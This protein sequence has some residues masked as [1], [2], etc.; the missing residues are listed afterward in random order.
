MLPPAVNAQKHAGDFEIGLGVAYGFETAEDGAL[1]MNFNVYYSVI[2]E[3]R[4]GADFTYYLVNDVRFQDPRFYELNLNSNYHLINQEVFRLYVLL[5]LHYMSRSYLRPVT[6]SDA[7][8]SEN[9]IGLN[10]GGGLELD[11]D[12]IILF[13]EPRITVNGYDQPSI[14]LG[15]RFFF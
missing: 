8:R 10:A 9:E 1:G 7:A 15:G 12:S 13:A 5:G 2:D 3:I 14:T 4:L 11:Y 6:G